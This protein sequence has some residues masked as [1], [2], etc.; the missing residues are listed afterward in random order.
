MAAAV[1]MTVLILRIASVRT[2]ALPPMAVE[3]PRL[4]LLYAAM[5]AI[6][7]AIGEECGLRGYVQCAAT[8]RW[9]QRPAWI[10]VASLFAFL[11]VG[12]PEFR[13]LLPVYLGTSIALSWLVSATGSVVPGILSHAVADI[14][15]FSLLLAGAPGTA[16]PAV[17]ATR[18]LGSI[19]SAF[20]AALSTGLFVVAASR[21]KV[22]IGLNRDHSRDCPRTASGLGL[23]AHAPTWVGALPTSWCLVQREEESLLDRELA[24]ELLFGHVLYDQS[25]SA[26]A[27]Q[28]GTDDVL[29]RL[30]DG[31]AA[32]VHLTWSGAPGSRTEWPATTLF[33]SLDDAVANLDND[34]RRNCCAATL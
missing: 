4:A 22:A 17:G 31:R 34:S 14:A 7:A 10:V 33:A 6:V 8:Q 3:S 29:F 30:R 25:A 13:I 27:R 23:S 19:A 26:V 28:V 16:G 1:A 18:D 24:A 32:L 2:A 12:G 15:S 20:A 5:A 9:G 21:L 11:H